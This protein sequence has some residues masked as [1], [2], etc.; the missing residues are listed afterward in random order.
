[1][2]RVSP[3]TYLVSGMAVAGMVNAPVVCSVPEIL[4]FDPPPGQSCGEYLRA[5]IDAAGGQ[6]LNPDT[7]I[8]QCQ[9][10]PLVETNQFLESVG[11]RFEDRWRNLG[12]QV[13]YLVVNVGAT[14]ALFWLVR[15][16][17]RRA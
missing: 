5:Y 2:Y 17:K 16:P 8:S 11:M 9:F 12:L 10:C 13:V 7:T 14:F 6:I 15:V 1:M 3:L 4:R